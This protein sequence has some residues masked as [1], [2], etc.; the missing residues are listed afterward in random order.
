MALK[1][2][3]FALA[4]SFY[5]ARKILRFFGIKYD[6]L[7]IMNDYYRERFLKL[8]YETRAVFLPHCL[9]A[10]DCPAKISPEGN[11]L[12]INCGKCNCGKIKGI[13]EKK[14]YKFFL[15]KDLS[16]IKN[17]IS[18]HKLQGILGVA[19]EYDIEKALKEEKINKKGVQ[20]NSLK[21]IPQGIKLPKHNCVKN[22]VDW[23]LLEKMIKES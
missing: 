1:K 3:K 23:E 14:G 6:A 5:P 11:I 12:C 16:T 18:K 2:I 9:R 8:P 20:V 21:I 17:T 4:L 15:V 13:T 10:Q 19:C 7:N 22:T